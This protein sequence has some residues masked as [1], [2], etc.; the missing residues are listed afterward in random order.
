MAFSDTIE[1][2]LRVT[3]AF[4]RESN[5]PDGNGNYGASVTTIAYGVL[6]DIQPARRW[7][8]YDLRQGDRSKITHT[9]F[10]DVPA[11]LPAVGDTCRDG[12]NDKRYQIRNVMAWAGDHLELDLEEVIP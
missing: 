6:G 2:E 9:G 1:Q 12:T 4:T 3:C 11:A 10:F 7:L 5:A 8:H